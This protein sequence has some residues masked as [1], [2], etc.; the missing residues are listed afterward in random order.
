V[1]EGAPGHP[2]ATGN[3]AVLRE[4]QGRREE[5]RPLLRQVVAEHPDYLHA[6]CNLARFLIMDG[7]LEEAQGLLAGLAERERMHVDDMFTLYG[8]LA[9]LHMAKGNDTA[10][11]R[12]LA[13]LEPLV[14]TEDDERH[15]AQARALTIR[16]MPKGMLGSILQRVATSL[17]RPYK[18]RR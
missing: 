12:F 14:E 15:L 6:R 2:V 10:A 16:V 18:G 9:M 7:E 8:T 11:E 1:L 3:L 4:M 17:P 13:N 5:V